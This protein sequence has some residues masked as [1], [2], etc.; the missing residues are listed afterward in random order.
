MASF[1]RSMF[2]PETRPLPMVK[3]D[4]LKQDDELAERILEAWKNRYPVKKGAQFP[5]DRDVKTYC[6]ELLLAAKK[7]PLEDINI[8]EGVERH[9]SELAKIFILREKLLECLDLDNRLNMNEE[10]R[11]SLYRKVNNTPY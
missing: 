4:E 3:F 1:F 11:L 6:K 10:F 2:L 9:L 8:I 7:L 5:S